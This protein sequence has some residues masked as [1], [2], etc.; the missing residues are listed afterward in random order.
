MADLIRDWAG[1]ERLFRL[2]FGGV[3]DLQEA[4]HGEPVG[5]I[6]VRIAT[7]RFDARDVWQ[8]IRLALVGGGMSP[9]E[10][11]RLMDDHFDAHPYLQHAELAGD[12]LTALMTG[13][14][15]SGR[16]DA[17]EPEAIR[18]SEVL[19]LCRT[20]NLSP[21][22]LRAMRYSDVINLVAGFNAAG[23]GRRMQPPTEEEFL[24]M[25]AKYEP[26]AAI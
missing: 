25:L 21:V 20:F 13:I 10:A 11:K 15:S 23:A 9:V 26:D 6:F 22:D 17:A 8:V 18:I 4:R 7:G 14:E 16:S 24:E 3:L 12:I 2:T 19:Q 5:A 1:Q